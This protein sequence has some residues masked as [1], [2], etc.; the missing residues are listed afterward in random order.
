MRLALIIAAFFAAAPVA[1]QDDIFSHSCKD[2][3]EAF[4]APSEMEAGIMMFRGLEG[5]AEANRNAGFYSGI[6]Y[7]YITAKT[8]DSQGAEWIKR[9][10]AGDAMT[11]GEVLHTF[12]QD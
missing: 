5:V 2:V 12:D 1:A 8:G 10:K 6:A 3:I 9:C 11:F 4:L 7:G